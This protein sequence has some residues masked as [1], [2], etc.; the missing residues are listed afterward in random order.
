MLLDR[1]DDRG[2]K[3]LLL[4]IEQNLELTEEGGRAGYVYLLSLIHI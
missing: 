2:L 3:H 4:A 1:N